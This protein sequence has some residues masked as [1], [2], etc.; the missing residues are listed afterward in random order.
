MHR[1]QSWGR[2]R[3]SAT[4]YVQDVAAGDGRVTIDGERNGG[5]KGMREGAIEYVTNN[6]EMEGHGNG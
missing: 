2:A 1:R 5:R 6:G 3:D 4:T